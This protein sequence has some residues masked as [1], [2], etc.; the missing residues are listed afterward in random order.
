PHCMPS[1]EA[2]GT[3]VGSVGK[4][5]ESTYRPVNRVPRCV[6][7]MPGMPRMPRMPRMPHESPGGCL[8]R[9]QTGDQRAVLR[10][11]P[12]RRACRGVAC[13]AL[14]SGGR[15][16]GNGATY[17]TKHPLEQCLRPCCHTEGA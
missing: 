5:Y 2:C 15:W 10:A 12:G 17:V 8:I 9:C 4:A 13:H 3:H 6:P 7:V 1:V 14:R 16:D 11:E